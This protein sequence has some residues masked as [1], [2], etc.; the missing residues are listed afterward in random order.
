LRGKL[1]KK[2]IRNRLIA[3]FLIS[4]L[5]PGL[6]VTSVVYIRSTEIITKKTN[7]LIEKNL[8][9]V[10]LIIRQRFEFI[11]ELTTL[12]SINPTINQVLSADKT[13]DMRLNVTQIL[14]LD[15]AISAYYLS[16]Y[17]VLP[18]SSVV[19]TIYLIDKPDYS[20]YRLSSKVR[21]ISEISHE[22]WFP[23]L[24]ARNTIVSARED[25]VLI[26]R[27][28]YDLKDVDKAVYAALLTIE[29][30]KRY[31]NDLLSS[32][33]MF[34]GTALSV[35]DSS[36][37]TILAGEHGAD[38]LKDARISAAL[39][40]AAGNA[41]TSILRGTNGK[42]VLVSSRRLESIGWTF[43]SVTD[44]SAVNS[45]QNTLTRIAAALILVCMAFALAFALLFSS[46]ITKPIVKLV[47]SM[48]SVADGT[49]AAEIDY[50]TDDEFGYLVAQYKAMMAQIRELIGRLY[51]SEARKREAE[52]RAKDAQL[53]ALQA[54]INPH[55]LYNT[56]DSINLHAQREK[57]P[58][59][60]AMIESLAN[61]Y[62]YGLSRGQ[63][64]ITV[65]EEV[66]HVESYLEIQ[67]LRFGD[68]LLYRIEIPFDIRKRRIVNFVLQPLVENAIQH[69]LQRVKGDWSIGITAS[70]DD[71][72]IVIRIADNGFGADID[73]LNGMLRRKSSDSFGIFNVQERLAGAYGADYGLSF[74]RNEPRGVVAEIRLPETE[75]GRE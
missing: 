8:D 61:F 6:A 16:N 13:K 63:D 52:I 9:S 38:L 70:S 34:P 21:D 27:K 14:T 43:A 17:Y 37:R 29:I 30:N 68:R 58:A 22:E 32:R 59:I 71:R 55:F 42:R 12:I 10:S 26:A 67:K 39:A 47:G 23:L 41:E 64:V 73:A 35:L 56:L 1:L 46:K 15:R 31:F 53:H 40:E 20:R 54:Q 48:S 5:I 62:R 49:L 2:R 60:S 65:D 18:N 19:P 4:I 33:T 3:Y 7:E 11:N 66:R 24:A 28:L 50:E 69:G 75:T 25:V 74:R 72:S 57:I 44:L 36:G 51:Q 45:D